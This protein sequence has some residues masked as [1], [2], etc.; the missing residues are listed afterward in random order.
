MYTYWSPRQCC[1]VA[2]ERQQK[3]SPRP[4]LL[5]AMWRK[6][7]SG[8][9]EL[10]IYCERR[11]KQIP[12]LKPKRIVFRHFKSIGHI[13]ITWIINKS[14]EYGKVFKRCYDKYFVLEFHTRA[15]SSA[16]EPMP[17]SQNIMEA[18]MS[19]LACSFDG[20]IFCLTG[21]LC[22]LFR[23]PVNSHHKGQWR[24][25]LMAFLICAWING[26]VNS[27]EA[28]ELRRYGA[29]YDVTL[30]RRPGLL[31]V[32]KN[33]REIWTIRQTFHWRKYIHK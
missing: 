6:G 8:K 4:Y 2:A 3:L 7:I 19:N 23:S 27:C 15:G 13:S 29:H 26:W 21:P 16:A 5:P 31:T 14:S 30:A 1:P 24:G 20:N 22:P 28:G 32:S 9:I 12:F 25:A 18:A 11:D 10:N 33:Y 17:Y